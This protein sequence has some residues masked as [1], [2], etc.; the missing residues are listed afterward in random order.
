MVVIFQIILL[1][2]TRSK[3]QKPASLQEKQQTEAG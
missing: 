2:Q 3:K 1:M